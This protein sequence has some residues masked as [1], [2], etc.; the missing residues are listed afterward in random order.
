MTTALVESI[1]K[2]R[3]RQDAVAI[4]LDLLE[5]H[6]PRIEETKCLVGQIYEFETPDRPVVEFDVTGHRYKK[7]QWVRS[8]LDQLLDSNI[9]SLCFQIESLPE[10]DFV[11][12]LGPG[13]GHSDLIGRMLGAEYDILEDGGVLAKSNLITDLD[14]D[15]V[16]LPDP[17]PSRTEVGAK[18]LRNVCFLAEATNGKVPIT[19]PQ[20]QGPLTNAARLMDHSEM[21]MA[22]HDSKEAMRELS[23]RIWQIAIRMVKALQEAVGADLLTPRR[24]FHQPAWVRG[25]IVDD[26]LSVIRPDDYYD[27]CADAWEAMHKAVGPIFFHTCGPVKQCTE[28][29]TRLPGL[30]GFETAFI[31]GRSKTTHEL[32]ELKARFQGQVVI[33]SFELPLGEPVSDPENLT[34]SW[35]EKIS[36][37]GGFMLQ[38]SGAVEEGRGLLGRLG[39]R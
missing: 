13:W 3:T 31:D 18:V 2:A 28:V 11:P 30:V 8:D 36:Q 35:L 14:R 17:D 5:L 25:L 16:N 9:Q 4:F 38:V 37:G 22:C 29:M 15:L 24:R 1:R 10:S 21:L 32:E 23:N 20:M 7:S 19:Y 27:I 26:Y 34:A 12:C 39:L 6:K 33:N